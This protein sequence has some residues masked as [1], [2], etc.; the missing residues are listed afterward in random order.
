MN[1][2]SRLLAQDNKLRT[3]AMAARH[4]FRAKGIVLA[5]W[6]EPW[7]IKRLNFSLH[8]AFMRA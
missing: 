3:P 1:Q 7:L 8:F 2:D 4:N 6:E 5:C